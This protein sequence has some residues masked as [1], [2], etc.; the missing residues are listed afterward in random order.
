MTTV[1]TTA[2]HLLARRVAGSPL[3]WSRD[4]ALVGGV[5]STLAPLAAGNMAPAGYWQVAALTGLLT[6]ALLGLAMPALVDA[7]R[8]RVPLLLLVLASP[9]VGLAWG[10]TAGGLAG[11]P[12]G[13]ANVLLGTAA[14]GAAGFIQLGWLWFPYLFQSVRRGRTWPILLT[15]LLTLPVATL[16]AIQAGFIVAFSGLIG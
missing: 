14:G 15:S 3:A 12:F 13:E 11:L 10:A 2:P 6:G 16:L 9:L 1:A 4:L 8:G 5:T 7:V